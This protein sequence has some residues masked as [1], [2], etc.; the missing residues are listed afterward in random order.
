MLIANEELP[1]FLILLLPVKVAQGLG[2]GRHDPTKFYDPLL[3]TSI[4][5]SFFLKLLLF[6]FYFYNCSFY[7]NLDCENIDN[8]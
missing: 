8:W 5:F 4:V 7:I 6:L 2:L 1:F 3:Q